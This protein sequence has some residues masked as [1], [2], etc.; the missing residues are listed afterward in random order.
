METELT[1]AGSQGGQGDAGG[2][3]GSDQ[4]AGQQG[5]GGQAAGWRESLSEDIRGEKSY[6]VLKGKDCNEI[7]QVMKK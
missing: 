7:G 5:A 6:D 3:A 4:G 2:Q 1:G